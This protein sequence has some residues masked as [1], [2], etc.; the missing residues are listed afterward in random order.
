M[1]AKEYFEKYDELIIKDHIAGS[2]E[3]AKKLLIEL[4]VESKNICEARHVKRD[5]AV[6]S[7][8]KETNQKW[9]AICS[10]YEKKYGVSPLN[11]NA[12]IEYWKHVMPELSTML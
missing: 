10:L 8:L 5:A 6:V 2:I 11:R 4:S 1:K 12:F 3:S 7:V 9:N